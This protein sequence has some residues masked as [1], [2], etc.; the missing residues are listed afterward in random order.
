M[1]PAPKVPLAPLTTLGVGGPAA[2]S[3]RI[4]READIPSAVEWAAARGLP[5]MALGGGSNLVVSDAGYAGLVLRIGLRGLREL[6]PGVLEAAAG[7]NWDAV[8]AYAVALEWGGIEC[9]SGI[10]GLAGATPVQNVGAYGQELAEVVER[11]RAWDRTSE[12][13]VD[14]A[15]GS[16]GF[17]YRASRFNQLDRGRFLITAVR[18]R[19][20]PGGAPGLRYPELRER[21]AGQAS[22]PNAATLTRPE[23]SGRALPLSEIRPQP[24][25]GEGVQKRAVAPTLADVRAAVLAIRRSKAMVLD[26][27]DP[28]SRSVGSFFKNPVVAAAIAGDLERRCGAAPPRYPAADGQIKLSAAWL[29]EQAGFHKGFALPGSRARLSRRHVLAIVNDGGATAAEVLVLAHHIQALTAEKTCIRLELEPE[30]VGFA[31]G[32][33]GR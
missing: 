22:P 11:V 26:P 15:P 4:E 14:L 13:F 5:W 9:L 6:A 18:L 1:N 10:P 7:E 27:N 25:P 8:V 33:A 17:G 28:E 2:F 3:I 19:L 12:T 29:L 30:L 24:D 23:Q 21:L 31:D 20:R 32:A 16:C